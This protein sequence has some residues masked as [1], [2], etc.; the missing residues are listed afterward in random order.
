MVAAT[1]FVQAPQPRLA[2]GD[3]SLLATTAYT[4]QPSDIWGAP[5]A[6]PTSA[7]P[8]LQQGVLQHSGMPPLQQPGS[9]FSTGAPSHLP[10]AMGGFWDHLPAARGLF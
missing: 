6:V 2:G 8:Q 4:L 9:A 10:I 7:L 1:P 3:D 5:A